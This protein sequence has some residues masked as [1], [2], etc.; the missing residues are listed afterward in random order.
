MPEISPLSF[1]L[2]T[3]SDG[4]CNGRKK[5]V[6]LLT[7]KNGLL[8]NPTPVS[9][10]PI[11]SFNSEYYIPPSSLTTVIKPPTPPMNKYHTQSFLTQR[12]IKREEAEEE[13]EKRRDWSDPFSTIPHSLPRHF[14]FISY[15]VVKIAISSSSHTSPGP[16]S[17]LYFIINITFCCQFSMTSPFVPLSYPTTSSYI[18]NLANNKHYIA[19]SETGTIIN[20]PSLINVKFSKFLT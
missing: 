6:Y 19:R 8:V 3:G 4:N 13:E 18:S 9:S 7:N 11:H 17:S 16:G 1:S 10:Q 20:G 5:T 15:R 2:F 12:K 14:S